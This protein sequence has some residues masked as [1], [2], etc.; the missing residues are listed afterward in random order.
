MEH[1]SPL[2]S[3]SEMVGHA[4]SF[5]LGRVYVAKGQYAAACRLLLELQA[6]E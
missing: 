6:G 2:F 3:H 4:R 1:S 5:T